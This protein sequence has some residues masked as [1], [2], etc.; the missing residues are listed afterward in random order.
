MVRT[1][2]YLSSAI[3][4]VAIAALTPFWHNAP[5]LLII[6]IPII[7]LGLYDIKSSHNILRNYPVIGHIRYA[8]EFIRPEIQQYFVAT[9]LSGRPFN[10]EQR[11]LVY[12]RAKNVMD[13]HPFGTEHDITEQ[14]YEYAYHSIKVKKVPA[15]EA[16]I[17]VG[18]PQCTE[19]YNASIMNI[20]AMS[21]GALSRNA[22]R[23]LNLGAKLAN[24]YQISL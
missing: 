14:G 2:F 8:F 17:Q 10:R 21:Y 19:P 6:V 20:S 18:G 23:A 16:R 4:L 13:T 11:S 9:N 22:V 5:Y 1:I 7:L 15:S 12:Q 3:S 24:I